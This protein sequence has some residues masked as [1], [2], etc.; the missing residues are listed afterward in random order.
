MNIEKEIKNLK[1]RMDAIEAFTAAPTTP[2]KPA[3]P[4]TDWATIDYSV[5]PKETFDK[6]G[7]KPFQIMK[8][9]A[10]KKGN[11]MRKDGE[12]WNN[13]NYSDAKE[14]ANDLDFSL[15]TIQQMLTLLA[16]YKQQHSNDASCYHDEFLGIQ[17][18]SYSHNVAYEWIEG[19]GA[20][21]RGGSWLNGSVDGPFA[22]SLNDAP[23]NTYSYLGFRCSRDVV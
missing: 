11:V 16:A 14:V 20:F 1:Q 6:Y 21:I 7:A 18:L 13:I 10:R 23:S 9:K 12:V 22:L 15:P 4:D 19:P 2:T 8:R 17:E 3:T 5:I